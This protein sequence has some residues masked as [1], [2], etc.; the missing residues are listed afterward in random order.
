LCLAGQPRSLQRLS[1]VG[2]RDLACAL[3]AD[4]RRQG[5][6][7]GYRCDEAM[8]MKPW[9]WVAASAEVVA[10]RPA[11]SFVQVSAEDSKVPLTRLFCL[12]NSAS[13]AIDW[14][15]R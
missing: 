1:A 2:G 10:A 4:Q 12:R 5:R 11:A 8:V 14:G 6:D 3:A 9:Y 15:C 13:R 7:M